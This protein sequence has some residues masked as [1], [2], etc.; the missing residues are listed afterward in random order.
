MSAVHPEGETH[1]QLVERAFHLRDV[2]E[3]DTA[4]ALF[5][6][7][8]AQ[9][10][11]TRDRLYLQLRYAC[12]LAGM[13]RNAEVITIARQVADQARREGYHAE[14]A[15]AMGL[16]VDDHLANSR[17]ALA[18]DALAEASYALE[19]A[20]ECPETYL[21]THNLAITYAHWGFA[22]KSL[23]LFE[24]ARRIAPDNV[25]RYRVNANSAV[26]Y[27]RA[28]IDTADPIERYQLLVDGIAAATAAIS[29]TGTVEIF[30][31]TTA[32]AH[33][34]MLNLLVGNFEEAL[35]DARRAQT[36]GTE[37]HLLEEHAVAAIAESAA[38]WRLRRDPT[39]LDLAVRA[40]QHAHAINYPDFVQIALDVEVEVLWELGRFAEARA[41]LEITNQRLLGQLRHEYIARI[42]HVQ[43]GISHRRTAAESET[44]SLTGLRNRRFLS[45]TL[46]TF[47]QHGSPVTVGVLD[48]DGFKQVNDVYSYSLGDM[49]LQD[50]ARLLTRACR[51]ADA[52]IR[53]G[54]DEFVIAL[55]DT[56][57]VTGLA[58]FER[59][60]ELI[61]SHRFTG[62]PD[63][64]R[65]SAS[66]GVSV[67][68]SHDDPIAVVT[69]AQESLQRAKRAGRNCIVVA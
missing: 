44:D 36:L 18:A 24:R 56:D 38:L 41:Q 22:S 69:A 21:V 10:A 64:V 29:D 52:V 28:A 65:L 9:A 61:S 63:S 62:L 27:S 2:G 59:A 40:K 8:A 45:R 66:V 34:A 54:G 60:R 67:G 16:I 39:A 31:L 57:L 25:E 49:V 19:L 15:D 20:A 50:V 26:A 43:L 35:L 5:L 4:A 37:L 14:L 42:D 1:E 6:R 11:T 68:G 53:L 7:A 23:E 51:R 47:L 3:I 13:A 48:L 46:H 12:S 55:R 17:L 33:R 58:V 30:A 32:L